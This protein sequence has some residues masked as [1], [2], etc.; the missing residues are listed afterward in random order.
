M[1]NQD[2]SDKTLA[3]FTLMFTK[4]ANEV[5]IAVLDEVISGSNKGELLELLAS[6][7]SV[8]LGEYYRDKLA[9]ENANDF[10]YYLWSAII[11]VF[12]TLSPAKS[13]D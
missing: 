5:Y 9:T 7:D 2:E 12:F 11:D 4:T 6:L 1:L 8:N 10:V 3:E 13:I